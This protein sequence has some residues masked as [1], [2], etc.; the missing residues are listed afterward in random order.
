MVPV[1]QSISQSTSPFFSPKA[2]DHMSIILWHMWWKQ[3]YNFTVHSL[4]Q[5]LR[6]VG[7]NRA[8]SWGQQDLEADALRSVWSQWEFFFPWLGVSMLADS[9]RS[10]VS[11]QVSFQRIVQDWD[12]RNSWS[13]L[14][15]SPM[16]SVSVHVCDSANRGAKVVVFWVHTRSQVFVLRSKGKFHPRVPEVL[17]LSSYSKPPA[18]QVLNISLIILQNNYSDININKLTTH[19]MLFYTVKPFIKDRHTGASWPYEYEL[20]INSF[21][22]NTFPCLFVKYL[23]LLVTFHSPA[24]V[25][26]FSH[27]RFIYTCIGKDFRRAQTTNSAVI[28]LYLLSLL[29]VCVSVRKYV[30]SLAGSNA[31]E[32]RQSEW[33]LCL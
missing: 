18:C 33:S 30:S 25:S 20:N 5:L 10:G 14:T 17:H 28:P 19:T 31:V 4:Y 16:I 6:A 8:T 22:A 13:T 1:R 9:P 27:S 29:H 26:A 3:T 24:S 15:C 21:I 12:G 23:L 7:G 2:S 32:F 11:A